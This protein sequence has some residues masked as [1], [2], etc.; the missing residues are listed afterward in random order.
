MKTLV[1]ITIIILC[2]LQT[3]QAQTDSLGLR[4]SY[5]IW[6]IS[7][8]KGRI[9]PWGIPS[10]QGRIRQGTLYEVKDSSLIISKSSDYRLDFKEK[11]DM[12]KI[13]VRSIDV[14]KIRKNGNVGQGVLIGALSGLIAGG[15][16]D[17]ILLTSWNPQKTN[18][19]SIEYN[20]KR[21]LLIAGPIGL[22]G[23]GIG[24]GSAVGSVKITIPIYGSR[25][26]FDLNKNML[27][28]YSVK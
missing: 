23:I 12:T 24:V 16:M 27:K 22:L 26:K 7:T 17:L 18:F 1:T 28:E 10:E 21:I 5:R 25:E 4:K 2:F 8:E 14:I 19:L 9:K 3:L 20:I 6:I 15:V 13:D 11:L